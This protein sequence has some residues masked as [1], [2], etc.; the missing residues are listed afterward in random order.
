MPIH[1]AWKIMLLYGH[2]H[3]NIPKI[4]KAIRKTNV[5]FGG[6]RCIYDLLMLFCLP[7]LPWFSVSLFFMLPYLTCRFRKT[8]K[9][10]LPGTVLKDGVQAYKWAKCAHGIQLHYT[11]ALH[12]SGGQERNRSILPEALGD[13]PNDAKDAIRRHVHTT[14]KTRSLSAVGSL[15]G[16][17]LKHS[18]RDFIRRWLGHANTSPAPSL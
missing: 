10:R 18:M 3:K 13:Q 15:W 4:H 5:D 7:C 17:R 6:T 2:F 16:G 8:V 9:T 12:V 14:W 11:H 1:T